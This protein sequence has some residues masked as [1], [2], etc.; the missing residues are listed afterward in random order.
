MATSRGVACIT[1]VDEGAR[2][3]GGLRGPI[4]VHTHT[5]QKKIESLFSMGCFLE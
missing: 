1:V 3:P 2:P 4:G 5:P